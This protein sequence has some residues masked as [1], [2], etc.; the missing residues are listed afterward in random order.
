MP[1]GSMKERLAERTAN[2]GEEVPIS[3]PDLERASAGKPRGEFCQMGLCRT[4]RS[5]YKHA[6]MS[7]LRREKKGQVSAEK[8][9]RA[10]RKLLVA[11]RSEIAIRVF[12]AATEV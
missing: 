10:F 12:R 7:A 3:L 6:D 11:N 4:D 5:R 9:P 1:D 8:P 2:P